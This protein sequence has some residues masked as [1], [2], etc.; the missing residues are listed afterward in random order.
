MSDLTPGEGYASI[1]IWIAR[2]EIG[3]ICVFRLEIGNEEEIN[4]QIDQEV[5]QLVAMRAVSS[6]SWSFKH[7]ENIK[8]ELQ[9]LQ[10]PEVGVVRTVSVWLEL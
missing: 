4:D 2:P 3:T 7:S 10:A 8:W 1:E 5:C 9:A 6:S